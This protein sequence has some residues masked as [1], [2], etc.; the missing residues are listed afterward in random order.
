[1]VT[2]GG[3]LKLRLVLPL[4]IRVPLRLWLGLPQELPVIDMV[5]EDQTGAYR[6]VQAKTLQIA[7]TMNVTC[8]LSY[9]P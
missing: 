5:T 1:M 4:G 3:M 6:L 8:L 9:S 2:V 7:S